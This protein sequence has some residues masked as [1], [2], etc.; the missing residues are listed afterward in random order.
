MIRRASTIDLRFTQLPYPHGKATELLYPITGV[1][2]KPTFVVAD[3]RGE[4][5]NSSLAKGLRLL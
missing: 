4:R 5:L 1:G 3:R 2:C